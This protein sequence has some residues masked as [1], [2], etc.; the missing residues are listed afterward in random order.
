MVGTHVV[1]S[2]T[3]FVINSANSCI[4]AATLSYQA[5]MMG[6]N[7]ATGII[8]KPPPAAPAPT[9]PTALPSPVPSESNATDT[10]AA[11][12]APVLAQISALKTLLY[13]KTGVPADDADW[14]SIPQGGAYVKTSLTQQQK[15]LD[16]TKPISRPLMVII[17]A[18]IPVCPSSNTKR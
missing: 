17:N 3:T 10:G 16:P 18:C 6:V 5:K 7:T 2:L 12:V 1:E 8:N 11:Y 9:S 15:V 13:S 14:D 4:T